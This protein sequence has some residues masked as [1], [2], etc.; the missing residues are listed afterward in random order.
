ML[1][2]LSGSVNSGKTSTSQ[3][4]VDHI[5]AALVNVYDRNDTI[6]NFNLATDLD[7]FMDL[8]VATINKYSSQGKHVATDCVVRPE[9]YIRFKHEKLTKP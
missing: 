6:P 1:I 3:L 4:Q 8:T 7:K 2:F 9:D 5:N